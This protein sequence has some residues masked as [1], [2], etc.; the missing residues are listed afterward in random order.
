M[1]P[2]KR[3]QSA[4][5]APLNRIMGTEANVRLLRAV[6]L[7]SS[8][9]SRT[10]LGRAANLEAKGAHLAANKLL[11]L[12]LLQLVGRGIRQL[13]ELNQGHPLARQL[14]SLFQVER[15]LAEDLVTSLKRL[16][17]EQAPELIG[18]WIQGPFARGEDRPGEPIQV[19]L[20][21][22]SRT[23]GGALSKLRKALAEVE[24]RYD[25]TIE[26]VGYTRPDLAVAPP[27]VRK[28]LSMT[29]PLFGLP[30]YDPPNLD[31]SLRNAV[32]HGQREQQQL[33]LAQ[34]VAEKLLKDPAA[35]HQARD[36]VARRMQVASEHERHSL[37]EWHAILD[38]MSAAR[39]NRFLTDDGERATRLRQ[40][41]PFL[42]LLS[43][44]ERE[45][46]VLR[47]RSS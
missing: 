38:T 33:Q 31:R 20:L 47:A 28:R 19:G 10:E 46:L 8:P 40:S 32:A 6:C 9:M 35:Q 5:R 24:G 23:L 25:T 44:K 15:T 16:V 18:A 21:A 39:L 7:E 37:E 2:P 11:E 41:L 12:G 30:P 3:A 22:H 34:Y 26:L 45:D 27:S 43:P 42:G 36:L 1:R 13:V 14:Q 29:I 4:A 17:G